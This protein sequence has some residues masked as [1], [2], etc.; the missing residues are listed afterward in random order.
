MLGVDV[1]RQ[2][3]GVALS[4]ELGF[5]AQPLTVIDNVSMEETVQ[6]MARLVR[7]HDV[8]GLVIG[9]PRRTDGRYGPEVEYVRDFGETMKQRLAVPVH[10]Q[11][12]RFSTVEAERTLIAS[13]MRRARRRQ[14]IDQV[15]AGIILQSYLDRKR[16]EIEGEE[17]SR[18]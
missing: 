4:D 11:D 14:V 2:R 9:L 8:D 5:T 16:I 18:D 12:E 3:I 13:G 10:Y 6:A 1:G 15:A 7:A 17:W